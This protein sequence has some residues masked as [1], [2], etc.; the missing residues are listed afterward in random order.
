MGKRGAVATAQPL[1]AA[2][3]LNVM[4][5]GGNAVDAAVA[6]AIAL[7]VL[8][9]TANGLGSD[10]F[11]LVWD[12]EPHGLNGSGKSPRALDPAEFLG[13][14]GMPER[15]WPSVTV[16]GAVSAWQALWKRWGSLPF[17]QLCQPAIRYA[18][19]GFPVSPQV[20]RLWESERNI[21]LGLEGEEFEA[22]RSL[23]FPSGRSPRAGDIWYSPGHV[24]TLRAIAQSE[25]ES[26]YRGELAKAI[27][28]F[29]AAT[30]GVLSLDD[31]GNHTPEWVTPL[32]TDYRDVTVWELPP[33]GQGVTALMALNILEGFDLARHP[34]DSAE[35]FHRQIEAIK[36]A[37]AD[38][39]RHISDPASMQIEVD[40]LL[41]KTYAG[42][43]RTQIG[44]RA[45]QMAAPG[46]PAGGTV[47]LAAADGD[48]MVSFIQSNFKGFGAGIVV[49]DTGISLQ[50][51]G[52][53]FAIEPNHPNWVA[54]GKRPFHTIIPS[55][56][57]RD[58]KPWGPMGV[59]GAH[60][61]PQGHVQM[62]VNLVDYGMNPQA[63]LDA[64]RWCFSAGNRV[65]LEQSVPRHI[66]VEL[67]DR[68]HA[69]FVDADTHVF[70]KGQMILRGDNRIFMAASE[71]RA[72]GMA[73]AL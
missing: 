33:N 58:G 67:S 59:M 70:G 62:V 37:F 45:I 39:H 32:S 40:R 34:R 53:G 28:A 10:A 19:E 24:N 1:A 23:F 7:T 49:P 43:R 6:M 22:F 9:P 52:S 41:D 38:A 14:E 26:F 50:N 36:L 42:Q 12:G 60:M 21:Y 61:Q 31:L 15:G 35:S 47:Y 72:D 3:G 56:L 68:G 18:E 8:E 17:D 51:R 44:E 73:I 63:A 27:S 29:A 48:L 11:A 25:G 66:A 71:P 5:A 54:P 16:P 57:T 13:L 69:I 65:A 20:S 4:A 55:F 2:T 30:G 64:P 46:L